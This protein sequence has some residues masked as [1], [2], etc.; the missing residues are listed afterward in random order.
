MRTLLIIC[1]TLIV[2][3]FTANAQQ[4]QGM[5]HSENAMTS[6]MAAE[7]NKGIAVLS[8]APGANVQGTVTFE[9]TPGGIKIVAD[10]SG[11]TP[12]KHGFHIHEFG[13]CSTKDFS[14]AGPHFMVAGQSHGSP[15][16]SAS[17]EGDM[18]NLV[19][20]STGHAHME[21]VD[22]HLSFSGANSILGR[23]VII[24]EKDD[25]LKTQPSGNSGA[26]IACGTIGIAKS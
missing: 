5:K 3:G 17:H 12:G 25:D 4:M 24:H 6:T 20:D 7:V 23:A 10:V 11:L 8:P 9:K 2:L 21:L 19:A 16:D 22:P 14:S 13:D 15:T 1:S 18:G 26:R